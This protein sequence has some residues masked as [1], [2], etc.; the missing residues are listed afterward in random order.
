MKVAS[1]QKKIQK[2]KNQ[3][4]EA[5]K[6]LKV[7]FER[8]SSNS[9]PESNKPIKILSHNESEAYI[10]LGSSEE[11]FFRRPCELLIESGIGEIFIHDIRIDPKY[12]NNWLAVCSFQSFPSISLKTSSDSSFKVKLRSCAKSTR[13]F[14]NVASEK[15]TPIKDTLSRNVQS[16][17]VDLDKYHQAAKKVLGKIQAEPGSSF[18]NVFVCGEKNMGKSSLSNFVLNY[19]MTSAQKATINYIE[20]DLGKPAFYI[21]GHV[22]IFRPAVPTFVNAPNSVAIVNTAETIAQYYIGENSPHYNFQAYLD[23]I[24]E[25]FTQLNSMAS[26]GDTHYINVINF[27]GYVKG[28]GKLLKFKAMDAVPV[29]TYQLKIKKEG[30]IRCKLISKSTKQ[31]IDSVKLSSVNYFAHTP[32]L[33]QEIKQRFIFSYLTE[34]KNVQTVKLQNVRFRI[35]SPNKVIEY[36]NDYDWDFLALTL[37]NSVI[38]VRIKQ[39]ETD[40]LDRLGLILGFDEADNSVTVNIPFVPHSVV[41]SALFI[42]LTTTTFHDFH[43]QK[44][45]SLTKFD[46]PSSLPFCNIRMV[47]IGAKTLRRKTAKRK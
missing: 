35:M 4:A 41:E 39:S 45:L 24:K 32:Q 1:K 5:P 9:L 28:F 12:Y 11:W 47:G 40:Q 20:L 36:Y 18:N 34:N 31:L 42:E 30:E 44:Q 17:F 3:V 10:E 46:D 26:A 6:V 33:H 2:P 14:T 27:H 16:A 19:L 8:A 29:I 7:E 43:I 21:Q 15:T 25:A 22:S 23:A 38:S 37:L 13:I